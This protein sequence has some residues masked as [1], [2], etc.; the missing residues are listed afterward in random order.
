M[1]MTG[2]AQ[3]DVIGP[4]LVEFDGILPNHEVHIWHA[5]LQSAQQQIESLY[6]LLHAEEQDRA[7]R[8]KFAVAHHQF[9][10]SRAFLRLALAGYLR[11]GALDVQFQTTEHG[12]PELAGNTDITFNLSHTE[13]VAVL[14][15]TRNRAV[16]I[17]VERVRQNLETLE[18]AERFFSSGEADWLRSQPASERLRSFFVCWTAKEAYIKACGGGLSMPLTEFNLIP[19]SGTQKIKLETSGNRDR[20]TKWTIWRLELGPELV[21][22]VAIES[23]DSQVRLGKWPWPQVF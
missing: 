9:V 4:D 15:V 16:G 14:A 10:I 1:E 17:D 6:R 20:S 3:D 23:E 18:I 7:S 12:K 13:G 5:D 8:F 21:S 2:R 19:R 11:T 22:A